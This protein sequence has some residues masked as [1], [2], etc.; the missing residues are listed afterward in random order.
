MTVTL[1]HTLR[2]TPDERAPTPDQLP[3]E[4]RRL[5]LLRLP[6]GWPVIAL[7]GGFP[8]WWALGLGV[9]SY[10]ILAVPMLW[11]L[12]KHRP[13]KLP[14]GFGIWTLFLLWLFAG[15]T[16]LQIN[17]PGTVPDSASGRLYGW[18]L[19]VVSYL[20]I[21]VLL[22]YLG[23]LSE[24]ELPQR[25]LMKLLVWMF[26]L[27]VAGG[28]LALV[29]PLF[30]FTSLFELLLPASVRSNIYVQSLVH[31]AASQIQDVLGYAAPRPKAP[32]EY[33]NSWG[34]NLSVLGV[35]FV[36]YMVM[37]RSALKWLVVAA[38][39]GIAAIPAI[40]S[41]NRGMWLGVGLS[42]GYVAVRLAMRGKIAILAALVAGVALLGFVVAASPLQNVIAQRLVSGRSDAIRSSLSDAA[43]SAAELSPILGYGSTRNTQGSPQSLAVGKS[44]A[45]PRCG[46]QPIGSNGQ[47]WQL[48]I[49]AG[50]LGA[51]LYFGFFL[52][53]LWRYRHDA[54][55]IGIAGTLVLLLALFYSLVYN[56][57]PSPLGFYF[58]ALAL[59]WRNDMRLRAERAVMAQAGVGD[60]RASRAV[61]IRVTP[62][63]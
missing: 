11:H 45:C 46:N 58:A 44:Q 49:S 56:A 37:K 17:P 16:V 18:G 48:L 1:G 39:V 3:R 31:P 40:H 41:L 51:A 63:S 19:R 34:N 4:V 7:L 61:P 20:A 9:F 10:V 47:L 30:E 24:K 26:A 23:N 15:L 54:S 43:V 57:V 42:V 8:V 38:G 2:R 52:Q 53:A 29:A 36:A 25:R 35:W 32:F 50:F 33:T 6:P 62:S 55:P 22:V 59:L 13:I 60:R 28:L 21:T 14:P 5:R 12:W 27:T